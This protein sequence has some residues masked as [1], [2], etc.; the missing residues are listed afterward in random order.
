MRAA[1]R[2]NL[3]AIAGL[4]VD[5]RTDENPMRGGSL[6]GRRGKTLNFLPIMFFSLYEG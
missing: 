5:E 6:P 3:F 4:D 2:P 1:W